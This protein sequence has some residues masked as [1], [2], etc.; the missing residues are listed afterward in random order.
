MKKSK[1][2]EGFLLSGL[3]CGIKK[4][5]YDLGLIFCR[6]PRKAVG[7]FTTN[8]N[9]SYSV[10]LCRRNIKNPIKAILVNS[11]NANCFSHKQGDKDTELIT[12]N[13]ARA[14]NTDKK[15]ILFASTGIIGKKLPKEKIIKKIPQLV[16]E[17]NDNPSKFAESI[18]TTDTKAKV[19]S[20]TLI[21]GKKK[22]KITGFAK[23][24]GMIKPNLATMLSF[25]LTDVDID[26][27]LAKKRIKE[28][29]DISFNS[30][31]IDSAES[32]N[33]SLLLFSSRKVP[34]SGSQENKFFQCLEE[35]M[36]E[37]AKMIVADAEGA[38]KFVQLDV[39]GAKNKKE[40]KKIAHKIAGYTLFKCALYGSNPNLG[41]IVAVLG[42][43]KIK[44]SRENLSVNFGPLKKKEVNVVIK[45][46]RGKANW[47]VY[48]CDLSPEYVRINAEYN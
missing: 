4:K 36:L 9:V 12:A 19:V 7:L 22:V 28:I 30:I 13:L 10:S 29:A 47:R 24:A 37:L 25:I 2:P 39:R 14:L 11:G 3:H 1:I 33:D 16:K 20:K 27:S 43:A 8:L 18:L 21:L 45:M 38:T 34:L 41:R 5:G 40:A 23:G 48:T 26:L 44:V 31:N 6:Q 17:L 46:K 35:V 15:N 32:T 42:Q